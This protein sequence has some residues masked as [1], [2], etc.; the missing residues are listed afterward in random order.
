MLIELFDDDRDS[1]VSSH[2]LHTFLVTIQKYKK[3]KP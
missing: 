3:E 1:I 2:T